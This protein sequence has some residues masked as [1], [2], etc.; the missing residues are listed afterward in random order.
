MKANKIVIMVTVS[1]VLA[2]WGMSARADAPPPAAGGQSLSEKATDPTAPLMAFYLADWYTP[3]LYNNNDGDQLNTAMARA[4]IPVPPMKLTPFSQ[5]ARLTV[6]YVAASPLKK[7][8]L[9]DIILFD[10]A[11]FDTP[12]LKGRFGVGPVLSFPTA[13]PDLLGSGKYSAGPAFGQVSQLGKLQ[14]G[15]FVQNLFSYAGESER[16]YVS[17]SMIQPIVNYSLPDSWHVGTGNMIFNMDWNQ[18]KFTSIPLVVSV[19]KVVQLGSI[20][21]NIALEPEY[22]L[23]DEGLSPEWTIR[24][25][26]TLL[27]PE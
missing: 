8:G 14:L 17:Q 15:L 26:V 6:P 16:T 3:A 24:F 27:F 12:A 9:A 21:A 13:D 18:G 22:N 2:G 1:A 23:Y 4:V 11:V 10:L 7:T 25:S 20:P 5:I 19:G